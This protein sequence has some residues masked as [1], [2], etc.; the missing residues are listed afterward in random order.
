[1]LLESGK[2]VL[3]SVADLDEALF[4][5]K[6]PETKEECE[7]MPADLMVV[8]PGG[9]YDDTESWCFSSMAILQNIEEARK[10]YG[11]GN[12]VGC[13]DGTYKLDYDGRVFI[14]FGTKTFTYDGSSVVHSFR[15]WAY[16]LA[17]T[18]SKEA[19]AKV[20]RC[21]KAVARTLFDFEL[22]LAVGISDK[23]EAMKPAFEDV[24]PAFQHINCYPHIIRKVCSTYCKSARLL[25]NL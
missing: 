3:E 2:D 18:E 12:M 5:K 21:T 16:S 22:Y 24:F 11:A 14:V 20:M 19:L 23:S 9:E 8:L 17:R 10:A 1:M 6:M 4:S 15:P 7:A 13:I 25:A